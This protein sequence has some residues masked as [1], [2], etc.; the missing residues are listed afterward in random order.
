MTCRV[1][2]VED[3]DVI[4]EVLCRA[5]HPELNKKAKTIPDEFCDIA[6][7]RERAE[8]WDLPSPEIE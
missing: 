4:L 2:H 5:C 6:A 1:N 7:E 8:A 3:D